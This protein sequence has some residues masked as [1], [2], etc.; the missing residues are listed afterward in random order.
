[1]MVQAVVFRRGTLFDRCNHSVHLILSPLCRTPEWVWRARVSLDFV[2][3]GG[4]INCP[5]MKRWFN[6]S[7]LHWIVW[8]C[9]DTGHG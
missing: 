7:T 8:A 1:M 3:D 9:L 6:R 2:R 5:Y 4:V